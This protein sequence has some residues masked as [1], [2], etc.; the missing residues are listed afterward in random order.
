M[1]DTN[2]RNMELRLLFV[3]ELFAH[4]TDE[5][6]QFIIDQIISLLSEE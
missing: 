5:Q 6:Q 4:L 1:D 3:M 2:K